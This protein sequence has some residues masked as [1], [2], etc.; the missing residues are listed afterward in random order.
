MFEITNV[1]LVDS[2]AIDKF[3]DRHF[4]LENN[5][6]AIGIPRVTEGINLENVEYIHIT[7]PSRHFNNS[8]TSQAIARAIRLGSHDKL[9]EDRK[10]AIPVRIYKY[11]SIP[12]NMSNL[13]PVYDLSI[14]YDQYLRAEIKD[15]NIKQIDR[16]LKESAVDCQLNYNR[17]MTGNIDFSRDCEY[18]KCEYKC[19]GISNLNPEL[20]F[21][22]YN[23]YYADKKEIAKKIKKLFQI[24]FI[25]TYSQ[26]KNE[27][28]KYR[29]FVVLSTL[30]DII[31]NREIIYN[32]WGIKSYIKN[33]SS[34]YYLYSN[35][36]YNSFYMNYYS[37]NI[38]KYFIK[39][40]AICLG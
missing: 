21:L 33:H 23:L 8:E 13:E 7:T 36:K 32:K 16:L 27:F 22:T 6:V 11:V 40:K 9:L 19:E 25:Y 30:S 17:N 15:Y 14:N 12:V 38:S 10:T 2:A 26:I 34:F 28:K 35:I 18:N 5:P 29:D 1:P 31:N 39:R 37:K 20:N 4:Q 3:N 24:S